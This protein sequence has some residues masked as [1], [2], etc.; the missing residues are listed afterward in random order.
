MHAHLKPQ[1]TGKDLISDLKERTNRANVMMSLEENENI[2]ALANQFLE[3]KMG[4]NSINVFQA[5][6]RKVPWTI[7][8]KAQVHGGCSQSL[9]A[10][11]CVTDI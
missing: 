4:L 1:G 9:C 8:S 5:C 3:S 11:G 10:F 2:M 7:Y 6:S